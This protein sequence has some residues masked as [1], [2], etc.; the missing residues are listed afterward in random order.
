MVLSEALVEFDNSIRAEFLDVFPGGVEAVEKL[1]DGELS[2]ILDD[3]FNHR[4]ISRCI[5]GT[6]AIIALVDPTEQNL[7]I[8]NLGDCQAGDNYYGPSIGIKDL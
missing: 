6:T 8:A 5:Q 1:T 3:G 7:W 2:D 4:L